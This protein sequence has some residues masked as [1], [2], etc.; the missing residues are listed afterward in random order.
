M[1]A[2]PEPRVYNPVTSS[3][4]PQR[5]VRSVVIPFIHQSVCRYRLLHPVHIPTRSDSTQA[6]SSVQQPP[7]RTPLPITIHSLQ[8]HPSYLYLSGNP[9][10]YL[11]RKTPTTTTILTHPSPLPP[12]LYTTTNQ[13]PSPSSKTAHLAVQFGREKYG[14]RYR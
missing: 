12:P 5:R 8:S 3:L 7:P 9:T 13:P 10:C 1:H 14:H 4:Q 11:P 6:H 2:L